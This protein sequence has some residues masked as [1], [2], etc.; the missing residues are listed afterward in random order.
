[1]LRQGAVGGQLGHADIAAGPHRGD[2]LGGGE[3]EDVAVE[4]VV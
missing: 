2:G 3:E 1:M 4:E